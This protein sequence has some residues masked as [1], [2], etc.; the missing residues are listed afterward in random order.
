MLKVAVIGGGSTYTP[1]LI[2]GFIEREEQFPLDELWLMD[3]DQQR[4][5]TVGQFAKRMASEKKSRFTIKLSTDQRQTI[6]GASYVITQLRVG[7]MD[8]RREDE[9]LGKRYGIVGQET[10]GVGGMAKAIRT[11]PV[12]LEIA[13][14]IQELAPNAVLINFSNPSGLVTEALFRYAPEVKSIG[15]CNSAIT[16]K[17]DILATLNKKLGTNFSPNQAEIKT[18]GLNHLTWYHGFVIEGRDYWPQIMKEIIEKEQNSEDP[19]FDPDTLANLQ[20]LPNSYLRYYYY[21]K[22]MVQMQA[23]WPPS[24]A[25]EVMKIENQLIDAYNDPDLVEP[26]EELM[27]RG[28]AYY[29]TIATQLVNA[30]YNDLNQIH[31]VNTRNNGAVPGWDNDW[32]LEI[33][34]RINARGVFPIPTAPL[35]PECASLIFCVKAYEILTAQAAVEGNRV[36]AYRALLTHPLGPSADKI[37]PLLEDMLEI[38]RRY[39]PNFFE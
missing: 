27:Q 9:Y 31:V 28:G 19:Y 29:S 36:A 25:E 34:C 37:T 10:T 33:P 7:Q 32:V 6:E 13:K 22:K 2:N 11:I 26:P 35:P 1:E 12:I 3:I 20:M 38:N 17:M 14:A 16:T 21:T 39:L 23:D 4:L 5:D 24:R 18:L 30:H 15:V 8:A